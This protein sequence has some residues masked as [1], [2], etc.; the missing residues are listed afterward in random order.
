MCENRESIIC[1]KKYIFIPV[2]GEYIFYYITVQSRSISL[3]C[4]SD[5]YHVFNVYHF[6]RKQIQYNINQSKSHISTPVNVQIKV[7]NNQANTLKTGKF[8]LI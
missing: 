1:Q 4:I 5:L 3:F 7:Q 8:I 2:F 6:A